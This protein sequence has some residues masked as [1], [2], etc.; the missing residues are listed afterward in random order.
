[1]NQALWVISV[2]AFAA[3]ACVGS[4]INLLVWR[5][6]P[7]WKLI[8][9]DTPRGGLS[10]PR[11]YCPACRKPI[12]RKHLV[13]I[14]SYFALAGKCSACGASIALRYPIVESASG[15]LAVVALAV[16]GLSAGALAAALFLFALLALALI[17][18]DTGYLPDAITIPLVVGGLAANAAGLFAPFSDALIGAA[19]GYAFFALIGLAFRRLRGR[20]GLGEGD[21]KLLAAIGAWCG[22]AAL[23]FVVLAAALATLAYVAVFRRGGSAEDPIA[24]GPGL[25][26]AGGAALLVLRLAGV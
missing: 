19:A 18:A 25:C 7:L 8:D 17:D 16:F 21:A 22:F 3:G 9:V 4:F 1:M 6:P 10:S 24:F 15:A 5:G 11:S 23:P 12:A 2:T 26:A 20:E 13:P 14:A